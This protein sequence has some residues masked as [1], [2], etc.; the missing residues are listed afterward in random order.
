MYVFIYLASTTLYIYCGQNKKLLVENRKVHTVIPHTVIR[1]L[2]E[3][4]VARTL[5]R[6]SP[7]IGMDYHTMSIKF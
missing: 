1:V 2:R 7:T 6:K 4:V 3:T 5:R